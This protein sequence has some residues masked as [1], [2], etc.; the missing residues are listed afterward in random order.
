[1]GIL[2][3]T[4]IKPVP[5]VRIRTYNH[6]QAAQRAKE[7]ARYRRQ[8]IARRVSMEL[9]QNVLTVT[10]QEDCMATSNAT[11]VMVLAITIMIENKSLVLTVMD[12]VTDIILRGVQVAVVK[13]HMKF[14]VAVKNAVP[15]EIS[16]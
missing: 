11:N 6:L 12:T 4:L 15:Q 13:P 16:L 5:A 3:E 10:H 1:M 9:T 8:K 7:T 2:W 14:P